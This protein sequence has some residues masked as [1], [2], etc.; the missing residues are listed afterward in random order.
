VTSDTLYP[1]LQVHY[2]LDSTVPDQE[3][4]VPVSEDTS[5]SIPR[6][7]GGLWT[8][9]FHD[10]LVSDYI[11][12][13]GLAANG[14]PEDFWLLFMDTRARIK[15]IGS[16]QAAHAFARKYHHDDK[17]ID[18]LRVAADVDA[19]W[20]TTHAADQCAE[21]AIFPFDDW[22]TESTF[23]LRWK[24]QAIQPLCPGGKANEARKFLR[25]QRESFFSAQPHQRWQ[26]DTE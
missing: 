19:V 21:N 3:Q 9:A 5:G 23:W 4:F 11:A 26:D 12:F 1:F 8:S 13:T 14:N 2:S 16:T 22:D 17:A 25:R 10:I 7:C 6:N 24:V 15:R 18:W 20:L